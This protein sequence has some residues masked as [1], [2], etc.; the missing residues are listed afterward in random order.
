MSQVIL[1]F[2][3]DGEVLDAYVKDESNVCMIMGPLGSGKTQGSCYKILKKMMNQKPNRD[4]VRRSRWIAV[5]NTYSELNSTTI[6]DWLELFRPLGEFKQ[7]SNAPPCH[8]LDF[9]IQQEIDG[10][11][12]TTNIQSE[13]IFLALDRPGDERKLRG[14]Q[15]TGFWFNEAKEI[16]YRIF[17]MAL[18]RVG[19]YPPRKQEGCTWAGIIGDY[20]APDEG[21]WLFNLAEDPS[22]R[23]AFTTDDGAEIK[24][25]FHKQP[26][27]AFITEELRPNGQHVWKVNPNAEN[28]NN[29]PK[30]Y[31]DLQTK[32]NLDD[33]IKVNIGNQ[34]GFVAD[35][36]PVHPQYND[37]VHCLDKHQAPDPS[38]SIMV[39]YDFGR[40]PAAALMQLDNKGRIYCFDEF[41][42]DDF[43][44]AMFGR[45]FRSYLDRNYA[46]FE[47]QGSGD[48]SG[49]SK[50]Q[51][52]DDT[53]I[54]M[55]R[56]EGLVCQPCN[57]N[58][59]G[60][61]RASLRNP[62][63]RLAMDGKPCFILSPNCKT[64]RKGLMGGFR[65]RRLSTSHERYTEEPDKNQ[66]SH[67]VEALEYG[68]VMLGEGAAAIRPAN[69]GEMKPVVITADWDVFG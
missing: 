20:N 51:A 64:I 61:R 31:Y 3:A 41:V 29:L 68:A 7:P 23:D 4:G 54:L 60:I 5:R 18:G 34:Y 22:L 69:A 59:P 35:G 50:G 21:E 49:E 36:K 32:P 48:P 33:W 53:P 45:E 27:A 14:T 56:A 26:P 40:T 52:T 58:N 2:K 30:G 12:V 6:K 15:V 16:P 66:Y 25:S 1:K 43:S 13:L 10:N 65:Y 46:D 9:E 62:M 47:F 28:I 11:I 17:S 42:T 37:N 39:G 44:A 55:L 8:Y 57:T 19:R 63:M 67:P 38:L 24:F